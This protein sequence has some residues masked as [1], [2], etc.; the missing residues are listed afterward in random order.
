MLESPNNASNKKKKFHLQIVMSLIFISVIFGIYFFL[1]IP[2]WIKIFMIFYSFLSIFL[3]YYILLDPPLKFQIETFEKLQKTVESQEWILRIIPVVITCLLLLFQLL[4]LSCSYMT[5]L[6][7][8]F[9]TSFIPGYCLLSIF[10]LQKYFSR[11]EVLLFA[12]IASYITV[13]ISWFVLGF[14]IMPYKAE[15]LTSIIT[16]LTVV[17]MIRKPNIEK[18]DIQRIKSF[19]KSK[20]VLAIV[21][22]YVIYLFANW[23]LYPAIIYS[24]SPDIIRHYASSEL[25]GTSFEIYFEQYNAWLYTLAHLHESAFIFLARSSIVPNQIVLLSLNFLLPLAFY[26]VMKRFFEHVD[27]R[28]PIIATWCYI[29]GATGGV[30]W[31]Y[32][33]KLRLFDGF[34]FSDALNLAN[35][36]TINSLYYGFSPS[37]Y[38]PIIP[39]LIIL[40]MLIS[41]IPNEKIPPKKFIPI[42]ISMLIGMF[43]SH[44]A[45]AS[46]FGIILCVF[47]FFFK[48]KRLKVDVSIYSTT[49]AYGVIIGIYQIYNRIYNWI[50]PLYFLLLYVSFAVLIFLSILR[51][52]V[53]YITLPERSFT[54]PILKKLKKMFENDESDN[55]FF[56]SKKWIK[57]SLW[58]VFLSFMFLI[59][60]FIYWLIAWDSPS[61]DISHFLFSGRV[62]WFFH[63]VRLGV[64]GFFGVTFIFRAHKSQK[65]S[66]QYNFLVMLGIVCF[67]FGIVLTIVRTYFLSSA[68]FYFERRLGIFIIIP[69]IVL[70]VKFA[71]SHFDAKVPNFSQKNIFWKNI[72]AFSLIGIIFLSNFTVALFGL[73]F[74]Y[75]NSQNSLQYVPIVWDEE[76]MG[77]NVI[78]GILSDD[79]TAFFM[80]PDDFN[81]EMIMKHVND[82]RILNTLSLRVE[83][84]VEYLTTQLFQIQSNMNQL[85]YNSSYMFFTHDLYQFLGAQYNNFYYE[86]LKMLPIV[87]VNENVIIY[88]VP[89]TTPPQ[90]NSGTG[91][92][93]PY[94]DYLTFPQKTKSINLL[95]L[96]NVNYSLYSDADP[97]IF[98]KDTLILGYD[99]LSEDHVEIPEGFNSWIQNGG[100]WD[101]VDENRINI[102]SISPDPYAAEGQ[103]R[104]PYP[105]T[106]LNASLAI[107]IEEMDLSV[108]NYLQILFERNDG[109]SFDKVVFLFSPS[110]YLH[111][112][113]VIDGVAG[114]QS[115]PGVNTTIKFERNFVYNIN[116]GVENRT[117]DVQFDDFIFQ[118]RNCSP[119]MSFGI[120]YKTYSSNFEVQLDLNEFHASYSP[121]YIRDVA[122]YTSYINDGGN[123]I[124]LNSNGYNSFA[125]QLFSL[126]TSLASMSSIRFE[127]TI[128]SLQGDIDVKQLTIQGVNTS[129]LAYYIDLGDGE[130]PFIV[131]QKLGS[132]YL[133]YVNSYPIFEA[134][135]TD[136]Y[137]ESGVPFITLLLQAL[138]GILPKIQF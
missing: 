105:I 117:L 66:F 28:I 11:I 80:V 99:P 95:N 17:N 89:V 114:P 43:L 130:I 118:V 10:H 83:N 112:Y 21:L 32:Y 69:F 91:L 88:K 38:T 59:L 122:E 82:S 58:L 87:F 73:E 120:D 72:K 48:G 62:P 54:N 7:S 98:E 94:D 85:G 138:E 23:I 36:Q 16:L 42:F 1:L 81:Y 52:V 30:G 6:L 97:T 121:T 76:E 63:A 86:F 57:I 100:M 111:C 123:V 15:I 19:T 45:E 4:N 116:I 75:R 60:G 108:N 84:S 12:F 14:F 18:K 133:Y 40:F 41:L 90:S 78:R 2:T 107:K 126:G 131:K 93:L 115:W 134:I 64:Y 27:P 44:V 33:I 47:A 29:V 71:F 22:I 31:L 135:E 96:V 102:K 119:Q 26:V 5:S 25:I 55:L 49:I 70:G 20:D 79:P 132:G 8:L 101:I 50:V 136:L 24:P 9:V 56:S 137:L 74:N 39:S 77:I 128:L 127:S 113:S 129:I 3:I 110:G 51:L 53:H 106:T 125:D 109:Y 92:V 68:I 13:G 46:I 35:R 37:Y 34:D 67:L 104:C 61:L 65:Y 103:I 124:I